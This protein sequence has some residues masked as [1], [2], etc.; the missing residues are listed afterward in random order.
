MSS[1]G[2]IIG[3]VVGGIIGF[4]AG[5]NIALGVSIGMGIGGYIDPPKGP[6]VQGPR[7]SD[8]AQQISSYGAPIPRVYGSCALSGNVVWIENNQLK[9]VSREESQGGKGG[10]GGATSTTYTYFGT[11]ALL[12]CEGPI[13]GVRRIWCNG[14]LVADRGA[15]DLSTIMATAQVFGIAGSN[16]STASITVFRGTEDQAPGCPYAGDTRRQ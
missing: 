8:L 16:D 14:K 1:P 4:F 9:E 11:F 12:L 6:N 7:L 15:T 5:G 10:G 13:G 3:G 2:Q